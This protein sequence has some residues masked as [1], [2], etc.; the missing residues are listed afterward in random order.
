MYR[1]MFL[2]KEKEVN[3]KIFRIYYWYLYVS[4]QQESQYT[5]TCSKSTKGTLE[6]NVKYVQRCSDVFVI[7]VEYISHLFLVFLLLT[8]NR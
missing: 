4:F 7:N 3:R 6:Q 2:S 8:F 5:S 1:S